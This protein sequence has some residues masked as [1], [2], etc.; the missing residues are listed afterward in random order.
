MKPTRFLYLSQE[1]VVNV[2]L[3]MQEAILVVEDCLKE[4]GR[5]QYENPPKPGVH[6]LPEAFI[7]AMPLALKISPLL[8][9]WMTLRMISRS[10]LTRVVAGGSKPL[11]AHGRMASSHRSCLI[12]RADPR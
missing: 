6:P 5:K 8:L 7:H 1:E 4:H 2:G 12:I 3:T 11:K 10:L 9:T